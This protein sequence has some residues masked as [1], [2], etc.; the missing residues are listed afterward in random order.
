MNDESLTPRTG[1]KHW[2]VTKYEGEPPRAG[3][4]KDPFEIVEGGDDIET[5]VIFRRPGADPESYSDLPY[6][7]EDK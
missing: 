5:R 3:E 6:Q 4:H 2:R 7:P 1:V